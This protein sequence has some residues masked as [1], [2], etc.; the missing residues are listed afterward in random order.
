MNNTIQFDEFLSRL[1]SRST[2]VLQ[3]FLPEKTGMLEQAMHY[4]VFNGGKRL[5]PILIYT[6]GQ[7]LDIDYHHLDGCASAVELV[8]AYS[9]VHDDL[10]AMDN[11][12]LRRGKPTCHKAF[13]EATAILAGDSLQT[14]AFTILT[15][16]TNDRLNA[17]KR[18][19][20]LAILAHAS[21]THGMAGGQALDLAY[22][23]TKPTLAQLKTMHSLK[24]GALIRACALLP[25]SLKGVDETIQNKLN[26]YAHYL[27]I[28]F[29]IHDDILDIESPSTLLG[30][31]QGTDANNAKTTYPDLM[32][33]EKA[34]AVAH[35]YIDK[36]KEEVQFLHEKNQRLMQL[37]DYIVQR[38]Y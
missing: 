35:D 14:L 26:R 27:G 19:T 32:N 17:D 20:M 3:K 22:T 29:Q 13:D 38:N 36:A 37:A 16:H 1:K 15:E 21:G 33:M 10:P 25:A 5:R 23:G 11:S 18:C 9:L 6:I 8:H 12:D 31:P 2:Q 4:A 7:A 34:K 24:T 30:K 28:A